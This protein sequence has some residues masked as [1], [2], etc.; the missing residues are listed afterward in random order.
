MI[1]GSPFHDEGA[2]PPVYGGLER[3]FDPMTNLPCSLLLQ[4]LDK[5]ESEKEIDLALDE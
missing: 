2:M 3:P 5:G 4:L 1:K